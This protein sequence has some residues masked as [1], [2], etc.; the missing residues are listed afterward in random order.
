MLALFGQFF[1]CL[2]SCQATYLRHMLQQN[3][4]TLVIR[5]DMSCAGQPFPQ[6]T[7]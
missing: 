2:C 3:L 1:V 4:G 5:R 7:I 6:H